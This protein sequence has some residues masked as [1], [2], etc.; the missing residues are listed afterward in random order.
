MQRVSAL[1][2]KDVR[3]IIKKICQIDQDNYPE[4]LHQLK[5][6]NTPTFFKTMW[7]FV[8]PL[9]DKRTQAKIQVG[10]SDQRSRSRLAV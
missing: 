2:Y 4:R 1:F 8:R 6:V 7:E 10:T 3:W 5:I 9:L